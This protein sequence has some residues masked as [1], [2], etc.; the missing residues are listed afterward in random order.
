VSHA[1]D[2]GARDLEARA[3][4]CQRVDTRRGR[5]DQ[6]RGTASWSFLA[7][8]AE[9]TFIHEMDSFAASGESPR[10]LPALRT[11]RSSLARIS[12]ATFSPE[13]NIPPKIGPMR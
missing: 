8:S 13:S 6:P 1:G 4:T 2:I 12:F 9:S 7:V 11:F 3:V 10:P 5:F